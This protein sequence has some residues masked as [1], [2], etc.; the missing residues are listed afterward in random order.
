MLSFL[1]NL[2]ISLFIYVCVLNPIIESLFII[3][4]I[5]CQLKAVNL[6]IPSYLANVPINYVFLVIIKLALAVN[7]M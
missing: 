4:S 6:V 1:L 2:K 7:L 3:V 5:I